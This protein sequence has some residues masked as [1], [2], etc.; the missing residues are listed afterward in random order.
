MI[1]FFFSRQWRRAETSESNLGFLTCCHL[2]FK[3]GP[4][5][6]LCLHVKRKFYFKSHKAA[7]G[8]GGIP[9]SF[10]CGWL[11]RQTWCFHSQIRKK[12]PTYTPIQTL[13]QDV[14][15]R[16]SFY[17]MFKVAADKKETK[18]VV[19]QQFYLVIHF[20]M[21]IQHKMSAAS[22]GRADVQQ[23]GAGQSDQSRSGVLWLWWRR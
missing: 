4:T 8:C 21:F 13:I 22:R 10:H 6:I 5:T 16:W 11:S 3:G 23:A 1:F 15:F 14:G 19:L 9:S 18:I 20:W 17:S 12:T 2:F 7:D